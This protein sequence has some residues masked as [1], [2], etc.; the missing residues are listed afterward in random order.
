MESYIKSRLIET[1][2]KIEFDKAQN[3][4]EIFAR[5]F[6]RL[7]QSDEDP[8]G[9]WLRLTK[10]KKGNLEGDSVIILE[11]L[12]EIYRKI[13][14]LERTLS[15]IKKEY[16]PLTQKG[17]ITT[18]GHSCFV[19]GNMLLEE[20]TLYYGRIELPTF[21]TRIIPIYFVYHSELAWV[22]QIHGRDESEWDS[23]VASKERALIRTLKQNKRDENDE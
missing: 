17:E 15:S 7:T 2:L 1:S 9:E 11:L 21:P 10:A 12:V 8:I 14:S 6:T 3:N 22:E 20:N 16:A 13:E 18:I 5:E 4:S 23:Y 19:V